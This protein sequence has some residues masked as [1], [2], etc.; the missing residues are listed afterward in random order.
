[1]ELSSPDELVGRSYLE[2]WP[3][4]VKPLIEASLATAR[5]GNL[6]R[7]TGSRP[8]PDGLPSWWDVTVIPVREDSGEITHFLSIARDMTLEV[9]ER[10]RVATVSLEMRHRLQNSLSVAMA[11]IS[12]SARNRPEVSEFANDVVMRIRQLAHV[13]SL[14]LDPQADRSLR[15]VVQALVGAYA[16]GDIEMRDLPDAHLSGESMQALSLCFGEL[17]TNSLK[18][19]ALRDG[20]RVVIEGA[21]RESKVELTWRENTEFG[22]ARPGGQGLNLI[23]RLIKT[24]GGSFVREITEREM[25]VTMTLQSD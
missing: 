2:R 22:V 10:E 24:G 3:A 21:T 25:R 15:N 5:R 12:L 7:F 4:S 19:G 8:Q 13:Q 14:V 11:I 23:E 20:S 9:L 1:M 18:Y 6:G 16:N 17:A